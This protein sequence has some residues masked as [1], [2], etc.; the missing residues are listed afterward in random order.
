MLALILNNAQLEKV[1][2][3]ENVLTNY[4]KELNAQVNLIVKMV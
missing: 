2:K 4:P 3:L 1:V